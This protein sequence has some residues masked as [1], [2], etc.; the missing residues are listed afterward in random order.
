MRRFS[1]LLLGLLTLS[2]HGETKKPDEAKPAK[3]EAKAFV[4]PLECEFNGERREINVTIPNEFSYSEA[5]N[6]LRFRGIAKPVIL[7][8][9]KTLSPNQRV[10]LQISVIPP[11]KKNPKTEKDIIEYLKSGTEAFVQ[12]SVE[13]KFTPV[14][15]NLKDGIGYAV[16]L[17]DK[18]E[19]N[20]PRPTKGPEHY[21]IITTAVV[22]IGDTIAVGTLLSDDVK[23]ADYLAAFKSLEG[24]TEK[25]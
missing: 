4:I 15:L 23:S 6:S 19:V 17:T 13:G 9:L 8:E 21:L 10:S 18:D 2:L 11:S 5:H 25:K 16:T 3:P 22:M 24:M 1:V 14:K 20:Q 7:G 12:G